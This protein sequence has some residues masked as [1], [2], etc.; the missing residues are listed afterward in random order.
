MHVK[1]IN[2][3]FIELLVQSG[4]DRTDSDKGS[5][6]D[7]MKYCQLYIHICAFHTSTYHIYISITCPM[8]L[9]VHV[10]DLT[11]IS[12]GGGAGGGVRWLQTDPVCDCVSSFVRVKPQDIFKETSGSFSAASVAQIT[13][14]DLRQM[15]FLFNDKKIIY[16]NQ[17]DL[18]FFC[19]KRWLI[20]IAM[21]RLQSRCFICIACFAG[22]K[23]HLYTHTSRLVM[24]HSCCANANANA[25]YMWRPLASHSSW[26]MAVT[27]HQQKGREEHYRSKQTW[28]LNPHCKCL[29][30]K[31][32]CSVSFLGLYDGTVQFG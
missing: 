10:Y 15:F 8:T 4:P 17:P 7:R 29:M 5:P 32:M 13:E 26:L 25:K 1:T 3:G 20:V 18:M 21:F 27:L 6:V 22:T 19:R 11:F 30:R 16:F 12:G 31:E 23:W 9:A 14:S 2:S 28:F 24:A